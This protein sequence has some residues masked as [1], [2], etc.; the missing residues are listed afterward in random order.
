M[1]VE[2]QHNKKGLVNI[3]NHDNKCFKWFYVRHLNLVD[4]N[5]RDF[6]LKN[7]QRITKKDRL[8]RKLNYQ[9]ID[10]PVSKKNYGKIE[11][12]NGINIK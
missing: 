12:S 3:Q 10:F 6:S 8:S 11:V 2:L 4:K 9:G 7:L 5:S 1:S